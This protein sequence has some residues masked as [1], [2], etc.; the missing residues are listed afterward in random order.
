MIILVNGA[1]KTVA[2]YPKVGRL[3][4]PRS[5][6]S[7]HR[8]AKSGR[9]WA[10]DNDAFGA[11]NE[12]RFQTMIV[13]IS[14]IDHTNLLWIACPD[15]VSNAQETVNRW[16]E[17]YPRIACLELPVAFVGQNGLGSIA[18]QIPWEQM[19]AFFVGGD[20]EWKL[21]VEAEEFVTEA[22]ERGKRTHMGR[23][24]TQNRIYHAVRIGC[25]SID[26]RSFSAW[27]DIWI[28]KG[29]RWIRD[30]ENK[31]LFQSPGC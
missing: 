25:D 23:V 27:P 14:Q 26:G 28:P 5:G 12:K 18:N 11:W 7:I 3:I 1:T 30:A 8:I 20:D 16:H 6:N 13:K 19:T 29:L 2:R 21:S 22:R 4:S 17:W 10:A 24:N 15:V 9:L 31:P